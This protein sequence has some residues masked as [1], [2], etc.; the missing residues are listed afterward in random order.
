MK[1]LTLCVCAYFHPTNPTDPPDL[2]ELAA[3]LGLDQPPVVTSIR[4][5]SIIVEALAETSNPAGLSEA[6]SGLE[7][8]P[9]G[10]FPCL[11]AGSSVVEPTQPTPTDPG[12]GLCS[13]CQ[14]SLSSPLAKNATNSNNIPNNEK[15]SQFA[16]GT[17]METLRTNVK[18]MMEALAVTKAELADKV[19]PNKHS[20]SP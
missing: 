4:P 7:G 19:N 14:V 13:N 8:K 20:K 5:G 16:N 2:A 10:G 15:Q 18:E 6:M 11:T 1:I 9:L 17:E 3:E 12:A